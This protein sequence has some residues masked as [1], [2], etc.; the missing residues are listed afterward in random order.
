MQLCRMDCSE[1]IPGLLYLGSSRASKDRAG[2]ERLNVRHIVSAA[3]KEHFKGTFEYSRVHFADSNDGELARA[4]DTVI[5]VVSAA[6]QGGTAVLVHCSGGV[7]RSP[8]LVIGYLMHRRGWEYDDA[9]DYVK[10]RRKGIRV[11]PHFITQ[12]HEYAAA[13]ADRADVLS[14]GTEEL[15][16]AEGEL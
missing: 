1:I 10:Q 2:L 16:E 12:L 9:H 7:S 11:R 5:A 6:E 14:V 13:R 3:G 4:L 8:A 15:A